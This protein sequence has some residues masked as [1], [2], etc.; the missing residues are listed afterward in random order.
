ME[1]TAADLSCMTEWKIT[2]SSGILTLYFEIIDSDGIKRWGV[3]QGGTLTASELRFHNKC[4]NLT[5]NLPV[6]KLTVIYYLY[7]LYRKT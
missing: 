4:M 5:H 3:S 1:I 2:E 6:D 7:T